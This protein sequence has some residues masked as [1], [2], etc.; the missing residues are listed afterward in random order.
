MTGVQTCAL[1]I[2][3]RFDHDGPYNEKYGR[4]VN[5][6]DPTTPNP[7]ATA[8]VAAYTKSPIAQL[9]ASAFSVLGG[10]TFPATGGTAVYKNDSHLVSPRVGFAWTPDFLHGKT[11]IRGGFG[12]FVAPV[13]IS[14]M[15]VNGKYSTSP[16][17]NQ[18]GF[19][20]TTT[21]VVTNDNSATPAAKLDNPFPNGF[22]KEIGRASYRERV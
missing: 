9:P 3:L 2:W 6:F 12:M 17:T 21:M 20:Q 16:N 15:D 19:S 10:L 8:A 5:G 11:V 14:T 7:L 22:L 13:V 1:P 18:E 4:T